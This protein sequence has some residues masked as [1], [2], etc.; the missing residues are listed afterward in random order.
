MSLGTT[1]F[2]TLFSS[3]GYINRNSESTLFLG[4]H[5]K[6]YLHWKT[7]VQ[8]YC[9]FP[10][11]LLSQQGIQLGILCWQVR[12][13]QSLQIHLCLF[14]E[15]QHILLF[16]SFY[17]TRWKKR[18]KKKDTESLNVVHITEHEESLMNRSLFR[19][20]DMEEV[21]LQITR[22]KKGC[23]PLRAFKWWWSSG[24]GHPFIV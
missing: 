15:Q 22:G 21:W 14:S 5:Y 23:V 17:R 24:F 7:E 18:L 11:G 1:K 4:H 2:K 16:F 10:N 9:L 6:I 19:V 3:N 8:C 12:S 13:K 20:K